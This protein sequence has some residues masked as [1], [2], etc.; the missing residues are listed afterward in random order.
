M[1]RARSA[2]NAKNRVTN[3]RV[4]DEYAGADG[5]YVDRCISSFQNSHSSTSLLLEDSFAINTAATATNAI[6]AGF[7]VRLFDDFVSLAQQFETCRIRAY[8][9]DIYD[10]NP[11][12]TSSYAWFSSFHDSYAS[13]SQPVFTAANVIDGPDSLI[14]PP[15]TGK[16]SVYWRAHGT[17]ELSFQT[18]DDAGVATPPLDFG[19]LRYS[20]SAGTAGSK[21]QIL[22]KAIVDFRG[23]L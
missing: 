14:V 8:R 6:L 2:R 23:R 11:S 20:L 13:N 9:F 18:T 21:Y 10:T 3:V 17:Q 19:G 15:G 12:N 7:Q 22:V 16:A 5:L 1:T 4:V